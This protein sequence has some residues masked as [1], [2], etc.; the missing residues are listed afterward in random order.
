MW[1]LR[2]F[3]FAWARLKDT[4]PVLCGL[5]VAVLSSCVCGCACSSAL[6]FGLV[7]RG[8]KLVSVE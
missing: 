2:V 1:F 8:M 7:I 3:V 4:G 6:P 5:M